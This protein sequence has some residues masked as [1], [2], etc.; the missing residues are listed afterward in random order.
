MAFIRVEVNK[1]RQF[2][3]FDDVE[4]VSTMDFVRAGNVLD[5]ISLDD[6]FKCFECFFLY[7][8]KNV[9]FKRRIG[10]Y[11]LHL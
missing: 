8:S 3:K 9:Q 1:K 2:V 7:S 10:L 4:N 11:C 5:I 6:K